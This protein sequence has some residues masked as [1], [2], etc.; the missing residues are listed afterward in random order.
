MSKGKHPLNV[1]YEIVLLQVFGSVIAAP[2]YSH[3]IPTDHRDS[4]AVSTYSVLVED[5]VRTYVLVFTVNIV[6]LELFT[7]LM[8]HYS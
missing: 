2:F 1:K 8:Q 7:L 6:G 4:K 5:G 3:R